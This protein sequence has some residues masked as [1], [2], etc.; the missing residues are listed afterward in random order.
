M[1]AVR[2]E[3]AEDVNQGD[4]WDISSFF[5]EL[6]PRVQEGFLSSFFIKFND[7]SLW[8]PY[9]SSLGAV[10]FN[11]VYSFAFGRNDMKMT[12]ASVTKKLDVL[13]LD[14]FSFLQTSIFAI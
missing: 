9:G 11:P 14:F 4:D 3:R 13:L 1:F 10:P 12:D 5:G 8:Q 7:T 6:L 2:D